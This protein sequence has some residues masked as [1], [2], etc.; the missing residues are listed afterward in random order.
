MVLFLRLAGS[1]HVCLSWAGCRGDGKVEMQEVRAPWSAGGEGLSPGGPWVENATSCMALPVGGGAHRMGDG[2]LSELWPCRDF[3]FL[4]SRR[5]NHT[6][7]EKPWTE[8]WFQKSVEL[9]QLL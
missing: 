2:E 9:K 6:R 4:G 8:F 3:V 1:E 5:L 7:S